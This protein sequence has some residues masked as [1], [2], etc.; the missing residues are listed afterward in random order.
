MLNDGFTKT[1]EECK[2]N[3]V[4]NNIFTYF[5]QGICVPLNILMYILWIT[6]VGLSFITSDNKTQNQPPSLKYQINK[7]QRI[8]GQRQKFWMWRIPSK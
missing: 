3:P 8:L 6:V 2:H 7:H 4:L 1:P 5:W